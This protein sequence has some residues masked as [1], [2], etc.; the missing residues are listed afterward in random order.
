M[1]G[2]ELATDIEE[3]RD[4]GGSS[5]PESADRKQNSVAQAS[6]LPVF[7]EQFP[8]LLGGRRAPGV[9]PES[10]IYALLIEKARSDEDSQVVP[11]R[12]LA[13]LQGLRY[14]TVVITGEQENAFVDPAASRMIERSAASHG[15][16]PRCDQLPSTSMDVE[17]R[18]KVMYKHNRES[19]A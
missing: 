4:C 14:G 19:F 7:L 9:V 18:I 13:Q 3:A 10:S 2:R 15:L 8:Q 1:V 17:W 5:L 12:A 6:V 16:R 11:R